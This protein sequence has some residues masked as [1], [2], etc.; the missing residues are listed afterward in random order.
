MKWYKRDPDA[1]LSGMAELSFEECGAYNRLL[2]LLYS[3]DGDV[4]DDDAFCARVFHCNPRT[5]RALKARLIAKGKVRSAGGLLTANRVELE[6]N[7]A[8]ERIAKAKRMRQIQLENQRAIAAA[9]PG[10]G[11]RTTRIER[12]LSSF[13]GRERGGR[14]SANGESLS[15]IVEARGWNRQK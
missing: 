12:K 9:L 7:S 10:M 11:A 5:W 13:V 1:A 8:H 4:P 2:D 15:D 14:A 3:R 6:I